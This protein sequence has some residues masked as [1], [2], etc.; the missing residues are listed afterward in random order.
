VTGGLNGEFV[1]VYDSVIKDA[2]NGK[3]KEKGREG[4]EGEEEKRGK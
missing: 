1:H 3:R 4:G 2:K